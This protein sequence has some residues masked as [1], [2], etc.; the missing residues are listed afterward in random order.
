MREEGPTPKD[1]SPRCTRAAVNLEA[2]RAA[3]VGVPWAA[4]LQVV[5]AM[6]LGLCCCRLERS[7]GIFF[8]IGHS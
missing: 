2:V 4:A 6:L 1:T 3:E 5:L 7:D 8:R